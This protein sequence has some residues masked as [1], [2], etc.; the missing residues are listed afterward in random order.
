MDISL[1]RSVPFFAALGDSDLERISAATVPRNLPA[2]DSLFTEGAE[3]HHAYVIVVDS[4]AAMVPEAELK[5][6]FITA[7]ARNDA[8]K[9]INRLKIEQ[10]LKEILHVRRLDR[11]P[12][13]D[14]QTLP[15]ELVHDGQELELATLLGDVPGKVQRPHVVSVH[16]LAAIA[17][18]LARRAAQPFA[19]SLRHSE[20]LLLPEPVDALAVDFPAITPQELPDALV[21]VARVLGHEF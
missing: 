2:G 15:R 16:R 12:H 1:L 11:R 8:S 20:A 21:A 3:A 7:Q 9:A 18:V 5:K 17:G 10:A 6:P 13:G 4:V 19:G 14:R